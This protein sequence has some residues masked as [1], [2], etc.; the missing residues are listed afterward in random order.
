MKRIL[1]YI[2]F[3]LSLSGSL[4]ASG[5]SAGSDQH[6]A[7]SAMR[8]AESHKGFS[9]NEEG[10]PIYG[11]Q[12]FQG[13]FRDLSFSGFNPHYQVSVGDVVQVM[14]WG[15]MENSLE[16][17][18]DPQGNIFIP[19][20]GPVQVQGV[21]NDELN[22]M[23]TNRVS[24]VYSDNIEVYANLRSSQTVKVFVSG[25]VRKP[26][27][28]QG[29]S[30]DSVLYYLDQA[31]GVDPERG[32][33]REIS[34]IRQN[35]VRQTV[36]LYDFLQKG[37][38]PII[39]FQDGDVILVEA[40]GNVVP[41]IGN[42]TNPALFEFSGEKVSLAGILHYAA[43]NPDATTVTVRRY[44]RGDK[45]TLVRT[46]DEL[47]GVMLRPGDQVRVSGRHV[48]RNIL[49][50]F[51]GEHEGPGYQ[52]LS[53]GASFRDAVELIV[54]SSYSDMEALHLYRESVA[55]RQKELLNQSLDNLERSIVGA[56]SS[57]LEEAQLRRIEAEIVQGFIERARDV[58]PRGQIL[59]ESLDRAMDLTLRDGDTIYVPSRNELVNVHGE[60][61]YPNTQTFREGE[62]LSSYIER[63]GGFT[64][65][66]DERDIII[67]RTNGFVETVGRGRRATLNPGDEIIVMPKP[68]EKR[69]LFAREITT[70]IYQ[71]A[72]SARVV[73]G[74]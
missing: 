35:E 29:F 18:V 24:D 28:Y 6:L 42:V 32:S 9:F 20:V 66:A 68:D 41:V 36:N 5:D 14:I 39:Q 51:T 64:E 65:N 19:R 45:S 16:L 47:D 54:P 38:L 17:T 59:F 70:I 23:I 34:I 73:L 56:T 3:L 46:L 26:G 63:A 27:L 50:N 44:A 67:I 11:S 52:V 2:L 62:R 74:L 8:T 49:I 61:K 40:R 55:Q 15:A 21:R 72:L 69:F 60:V 12:L 48:S 71:V 10:L 43:P 13:D 31:G 57:L 33:Y 30:S 7:P 53:Q 25:F 37:V 58:Q 22:N 4:G 1:L